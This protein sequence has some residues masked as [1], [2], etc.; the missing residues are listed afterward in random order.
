MNPLFYFWDGECFKPIPR[1]A[2]EAD[3][4]F[5]IGEHYALD[6]IEER[7]LKSHR[8]YFASIRECWLNLP[9][10]IAATFTTAE[11]L[12]KHA[13]IRTG[14]FDKRSI[15]AANKTEALR[16]A[17]FIRPMD[18]YAI[19]T[20]SG[21]LVECFTAKSQSHRA[22]PKGEFQASKTAVLEWIA[23]LIDVAPA[24]LEKAGA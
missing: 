7:S 17:A 22:M 21:S 1:H 6:H 9:N 19:V 16:L 13:L 2:K 10:H 8:Q 23:A 4:R 14:F 12:R 11:H 5:V 15:Q 20:V 3:K 24:A 18:E